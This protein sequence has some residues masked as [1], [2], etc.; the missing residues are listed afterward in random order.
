[1][2]RTLSAPADAENRPVCVP[3]RKPARRH[4]RPRTVV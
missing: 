4:G 1:M 3:D 2:Q